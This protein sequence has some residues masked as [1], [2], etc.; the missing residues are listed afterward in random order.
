MLRAINKETEYLKDGDIYCNVC[1]TPKTFLFDGKRIEGNCM[2]IIYKHEAEVKR[3]NEERLKA[4]IATLKAESDIGD[5]Y[6]N[7]T[8]KNSE[9]ATEHAKAIKYCNETINNY[10]KGLSMFFH[11]ATGTGKTRTMACILNRLAEKLYTVYFTRFTDIMRKYKAAES[12]T[13]KESQEDVIDFYTKKIDFLFIDDL[14]TEFMRSTDTVMQRLIY[15]IINGRLNNYK[16]MILS[17]NFK[18]SELITQ[19]GFDAR[20]VWR[21][22]EVCKNYIVGFNGRNW[23][24]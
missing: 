7:A 8:F 10:N 3:N 15:D 14:G 1:N 24:E 13:S 17:S 4:R 20:V 12:F 19:G 5:R 18:L 11:G 16:P 21:L 9:K 6:F 22:N 2:C 23:R